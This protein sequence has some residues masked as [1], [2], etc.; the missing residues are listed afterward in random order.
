MSTCTPEVSRKHSSLRSLAA[1]LALGTTAG[2]FVFVAPPI[3]HAAT[4]KV[5]MGDEPPVYKP[6]TV[7][8][9]SGDTVEWINTGKTLHSVTLKPGTAQNPKDS[10]EPKGAEPFD[11]G[12]MAPGA[13]YS[14]KFTVPGTY[15]YFC[16]PHE[17]GEMVGKV[18]VKK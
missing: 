4:V 13:K 10:S 5:T 2:L 18:V 16:I 12:F 9:K 17:K 6:E 3:A 8:I 7:T 14:H 15:T 11:S 1:A